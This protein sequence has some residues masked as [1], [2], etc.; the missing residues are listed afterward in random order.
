MKAVLLL[1]ALAT[2]LPS[3]APADAQDPGGITHV[4]LDCG[5]PPA[6]STDVACPRRVIDEEDIMGSPRL[7]VHPK[8]PMV[9][10]F[11]ALHGG[12]GISTGPTD[13]PPSATARKN[14]VHQPHTT[15][16]S[17]TAFD[18][19]E[20]SLTWKDQPY[21]A[22]NAEYR[23]D[24][25]PDPLCPLLPC[26]QEV[27]TRA[28]WGVDNGL[29]IDREGR[30]VEASLYAY[31]NASADAAFSYELALWK[32]Q[33]PDKD[34]DGNANLKI[35]Y[36]EHDGDLMDT[37]DAV[38]VPGPNLTVALWR[39]A[40]AP[41][42]HGPGPSSWIGLAWSTTAHD[43][44]WDRQ[45]RA[46]AIGP[47]L[48]ITNAGA[49]GDTLYVGCV[50]GDG[51]AMRPDARRGDLDLW[52][53]RWPGATHTFVATV[54]VHGRDPVLALRRDGMMAALATHVEGAHKVRVEASFGHA[55]RD[56]WS[57]TTDLGGRLVNTTQA[58]EG[59]RV[60]AAAFQEATSTLY[61]VY[62]ERHARD[63]GDARPRFEKRLVAVHP[64]A[65]VLDVHNLAVGLVPS[66]YPATVEGLS[67]L[68]FEDRHDGLVVWT[69]RKTGAERVFI[70][71]A[72]YGTVE[73]AE[74]K[75]D[76]DV[77]PACCPPPPPP[78]GHAVVDPNTVNQ[79][80]QAVAGVVGGVL[81]SS[82]V[83]RLLLARSKRRV[84]APAPGGK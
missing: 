24:M 75:Q 15:F 73:V 58:V 10:A 43:S 32:Q 78:G 6:G 47:C 63:A 59:A 68:V 2:L 65:G 44:R 25:D 60:T 16:R 66:Y 50:A 55:G 76:G 37:V 69:D 41:G 23:P 54:P 57:P 3:L 30:M 74:V 1:L 34:R 14:I 52:A 4:R 28:M 7:V 11:N 62:E 53:L 17:T 22:P 67:D 70:A 46:D 39:E 51:Y 71:F 12:P 20:S 38:A 18:V 21:Y 61:V 42:D 48:N 33:G 13:V 26:V 84:E 72:D 82:M 56:D 81:A 49:A 5:P 19:K 45:R 40:A 64:Q 9:M 29:A 79:A 80:S 35:L 27:A 36:A 77:P 83:L 31:K 8:D